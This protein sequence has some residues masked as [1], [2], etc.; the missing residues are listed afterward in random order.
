MTS[1][2]AGF[3]PSNGKKPLCSVKDKSNWL[4][5]PPEYGDYVGILK[6]D[7]IQLDFDDTDSAEI[8]RKI[9]DDYKLR[10]DILKTTRGY[11]FYFKDDGTIKRQSVGMYNTIGIQS[12]VGLGSKNRVVPL[13]ITQKI[14]TKTTKN[15]EEVESISYR[16]IQREWLQTYDDLEK[17]PC[18]F[19]PISHKDYGIRDTNTRNNVLFT[20]ILKLQSA[21]YSKADIRKIIK[22][23]NKYVIREPLSDR[24]IDTITRDDAFS[25]EIFFDENG[26]FLHD[27]FG[28]Y[29][30]SNANVLL[31]EGQPCIYTK[32]H[33]Y[34]NDPDDF[35]RAMIDKIPFL[36]DAQRKEVY[37]YM[38]LKLD[39]KGEYAHPKYIGL[40]NDILDIETMTRFPYSPSFVLNNTIDYDYNPDAYCEV[41]DKTLDKVCC[42]DNEIRSLLEEM[43]GYTLYRANTMQKAFIL[44][45]EGSNG[46]S[47][48]LNVIKK[49]LGRKNYVSLELKDLEE[50][51]FKPAE[52]YNKLANIGDDISAKYLSSS[53]IF[54]KAVTG[55]SFRVQR[56][57]AHSFELENYSTQIFC[58]NKLPPAKDTSDGFN[59]RLIIIPFNAK[60]S[61]NDED[62]DP[63]VEEKLMKDESIEYLLK[64]AIG[65]LRRL[66]YNREFTK[67]KASER[68]K[69]E[70]V[71]SN[72][73]V[74]EWLDDKPKI[75]N[76]SVN[77]VYLSY[78]VWCVQNGYKAFNKGNL[79]REIRK[80]T[81]FVSQ[82]QYVGGKTVRVYKKEDE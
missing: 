43:I 47:T 60:F 35:E 58:A 37:K 18:F 38:C 67:S 17:I 81:G 14:I 62:Y 50:D 20:Y 5:E 61:S 70:Y 27:R 45:G 59:R 6:P 22:I 42:Y 23:A 4:A 40:K 66:L 2:F 11:H 7:I 44:T 82:P 57:Y 24:E 72:N 36:K 49:L 68:E 63:F 39:A 29:M 79:S 53:N 78:Q 34:S 56:K 46:K 1:I 51:A 71:R 65:G 30:L 55:E 41:M 19:K 16:S 25:E 9:V 73:N 69:R 64:I 28:N 8:A 26:K 21:G 80:H 10:C 48:I 32:E 33:I 12:D 76:E 15:D 3:L 54:K 31:L 75:E 77:D 74:L 52:L 13:R